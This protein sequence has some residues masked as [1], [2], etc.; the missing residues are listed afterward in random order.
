VVSH[1]EARDQSEGMK[2]AKESFDRLQERMTPPQREALT[3]IRE[4]MEAWFVDV[5]I[6]GLFHILLGR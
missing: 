5:G 2:R 1:K 6:R 3:E 4:W